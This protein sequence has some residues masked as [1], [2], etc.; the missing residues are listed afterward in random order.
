MTGI[1]YVIDNKNYTDG[2][3]IR[4][5]LGISKS[6]FQF[7]IGHYGIEQSEI[8]YL[9]NRKLYS[10]ESIQKLIKRINERKRQIKNAD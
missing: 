8:V 10:I 2:Y 7:L 6:A 1:Y 9:Q 5:S 4:E 3:L